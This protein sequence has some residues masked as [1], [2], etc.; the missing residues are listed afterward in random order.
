VL[1]GLRSVGAALL[2]LPRP[3]A[4]IPVLAWMG[5]IW[6]LSA[7]EGGVG[8]PSWYGSLLTNLAHAPIFGL[9]ALWALLLLPRE[10]GWPLLRPRHCAAILAFVLLYGLVDEV[11]QSFTPDRNPSYYDVLTDVVGATCVLWIAAYVRLRA[12]T[13]RGL[14]GRLLL[15]VLLCVGAAALATFE[16]FTPQAEAATAVGGGAN[17]PR[18]GGGA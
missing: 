15:G 14:L 17:P 2:R 16:P 10:D 13:E 8:I 1:R 12:A 6:S 18:A 11:H 5:L 7:M 3:L 4:L 9:L